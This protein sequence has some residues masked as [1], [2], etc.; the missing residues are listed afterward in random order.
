MRAKQIKPAVL[1]GILLGGLTACSDAFAPDRAEGTFV[2]AGSLALDWSGDGREI[3]YYDSGY[4]EGRLRP[5]PDRILAVNVTTR[6]TRVV[7][8]SGAYGAGGARRPG[9]V[10]PR[11][12]T[13]GLAYTHFDSLGF[14]LHL[15]TAY[16]DIPVAASGGWLTTAPDRTRLFYNFPHPDVFNDSIGM[17]D[18]ATDARTVYRLGAY[19]P[20]VGPAI[21]PDGDRMLVERVD[22]AAGFA[23]LSLQ[24][25]TI[26]ALDDSALFPER[27]SFA[28]RPLGWNA[29]GVW[30]LVYGGPP[31]L[32]RYNPQTGTGETFPIYDTVGGTRAVTAG[33]ALPSGDVV[34]WTENCNGTD[35]MTALCTSA[36]YVAWR[37]NPVTGIDERLVDLETSPADDY[38][39]RFFAAA[40]P[41]GRSLAYVLGNELRVLPLQ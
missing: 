35:P 7:V 2:A 16:D 3:F 6:A 40:T 38:P 27:H 37:I 19:G 15:V 41:D 22:A 10:P 1:L 13:H 26:S 11:A 30:F 18:L 21:S 9:A 33:T 25:G 29:T 34:V 4:T 17:I 20:T 14:T 24:D 39:R 12:T 28:P 31:H 32:V 36:S 8:A 23:I 5:P